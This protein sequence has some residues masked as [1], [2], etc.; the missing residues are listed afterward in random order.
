MAATCHDE[1]VTAVWLQPVMMRV[2]LLCGCNHDEGVTAVSLSAAAVE[3]KSESKKRRRDST[4][5]EK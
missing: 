2:S 4:F 3:V 1:G 5:S